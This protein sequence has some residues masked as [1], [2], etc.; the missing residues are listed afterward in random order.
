MSITSTLPT[1]PGWSSWQLIWTAHYGADTPW[2]DQNVNLEDWIDGATPVYATRYIELFAGKYITIE[3]LLTQLE[4]ERA[5]DLETLLHI[6]FETANA[7]IAN[8]KRKLI[9]KQ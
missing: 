6:K 1:Y 3:I 4:I 7:S 5:Q 2:D 9:T 8:L